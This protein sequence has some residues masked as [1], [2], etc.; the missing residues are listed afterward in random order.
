MVGKHV[1]ENYSAQPPRCRPCFQVGGEEPGWV[2]KGRPR[3]PREESG[4]C[5]EQL[6]LT[7]DAD[8][9]QWELRDER[10]L[11]EVLMLGGDETPVPQP[12]KPQGS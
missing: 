2:V 3:S 11:E 4:L 5:D 1:K 6:R 12:C 8:C 10:A 9:Q 7:T